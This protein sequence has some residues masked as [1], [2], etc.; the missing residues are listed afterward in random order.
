MLNFSPSGLWE[1]TGAA[2]WYHE[3]SYACCPSDPYYSDHTYFIR[4]KRRPLY[5][6]VN[7]VFPTLLFSLLSITVFYLPA[8]SGEKMTL[9][10]SILLSLAVFLMVI[11]E[12][13][14]S[15]ATATPLLAE[16]V[17][18]T[19]MLVAASVALTVVV[20]NIHH[21]GPSTHMM[22]NW[23]RT[24]FIKWLPKILGS[25]SIRKLD[26]KG[27]LPPNLA[28]M[29][30]KD[31]PSDERVRNALEGL[32]VSYKHKITGKLSTS[33]SFNFFLIVHGKNNSTK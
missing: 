17:L 12:A 23:M 32:Q 2:C 13:I 33:I 8:D 19:T 3:V 18:F 26:P 11:I 10:I 20:Q 14:P 21:R 6:L 7:I 27:P 31:L 30:K 1:L 24:V 29:D 5:L 16:Y 9:C 4:I 15:T 25:K 28:S 22:P